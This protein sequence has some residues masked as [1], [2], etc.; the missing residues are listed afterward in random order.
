[1]AAPR[2]SAL[3][4]SERLS[5]GIQLGESHFREF[6]SAIDRSS[7]PPKNREPRSVC[8]DFAETLVAFSNADGGDLFVGVEDDGTITGIHYKDAQ[9]AMLTNACI[10]EGNLRILPQSHE[11][12]NPSETVLPSPELT[13][14]RS[15]EK[16]Q[17]TAIGE[18]VGFFVGFGTSDF[19]VG[20]SQG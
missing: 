20:Q 7:I 2:I 4:V 15:D 19:G 6:K 8:K 12:L 5:T 17:A 10:R 16:V 11:F 13:A 3:K 14:G 18:L 9:Y 1:V